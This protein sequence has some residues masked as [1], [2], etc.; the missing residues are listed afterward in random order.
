MMM[1]KILNVIKIKHC[2]SKRLV[3]F[4]FINHGAKKQYSIKKEFYNFLYSFYSKSVDEPVY[5][6]RE[7]SGKCEERESITNCNFSGL[8]SAQFINALQYFMGFCFFA[9]SINLKLR[10]QKFFVSL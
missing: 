7:K 1:T 5:Q 6:R 2:E 10:I 9:F 8:F 4:R 3:K